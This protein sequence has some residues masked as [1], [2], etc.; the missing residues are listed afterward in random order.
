M[1]ELVKEEELQK[2]LIEKEKQKKLEYNRI[3]QSS[4]LEKTKKQN[5]NTNYK[6][7]KI[8]VLT[9]RNYHCSNSR[10]FGLE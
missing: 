7:D 4:L 3:L 2:E 9:D 8:G 1:A 5:K 6:Q 10:F